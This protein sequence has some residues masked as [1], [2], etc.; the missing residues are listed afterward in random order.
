[1]TKLLE[2]QCNLVEYPHQRNI[3]MPTNI[4]HGQFSRICAVIKRVDLQP[5]DMVNMQG[6]LDR[7]KFDIKY[8]II[9]F[10]TICT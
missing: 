4:I 3:D 7:R 2:R 5:N 8:V 9:T 6:K 10:N 1:M